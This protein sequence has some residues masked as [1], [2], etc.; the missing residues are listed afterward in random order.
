M[1]LRI[2][3]AVG[4]SLFLTLVTF[5]TAFAKGGYSFITIAGSTLKN[6]IRSTD[7]ALTT[8][9][10]AFADFYRDKSE[11][12]AHPGAGY[13]I[14]RYYTKGNREVPFDRLLYYPETGFVYYEGL[15]NGSSE[16]DGGWYKAATEI[17]TA[18]ED[19]LGM[20]KP[21]PIRPDTFLVRS[22]FILPMIITAGMA[23]LLLMAYRIRRLSIC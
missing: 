8:D 14:T 16:Y 5:M 23:I 20:T 9:F 19:A 4:L 22:P 13:E 12:P 7:P 18:F 10:F 21:E 3:I 15:V 6:T 2:R 17:K 11:E 1:V